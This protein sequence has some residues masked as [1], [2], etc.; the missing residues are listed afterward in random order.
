MPLAIDEFPV[1][2]VA[3]A[4]ATGRTVLTGAEELRVK[5]SDRIAVMAHGLQK[6]GIDAEPTEDG[7]IIQGLGQVEGLRYQGH[8]HR[9]AG[10]SPNRHVFQR[11]CHPG[12]RHH[13]YSRGSNCGHFVPGFR[14]LGQFAGHEGSIR[15]ER[16][17]NGFFDH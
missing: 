15:S 12:R 16:L 4:N 11:G 5:E 2:F 17:K 6:C 7:M 13:D 10:R 9:I 3:A 1:L 14:G 8:Q